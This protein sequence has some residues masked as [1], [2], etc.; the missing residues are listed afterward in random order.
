[1]N[2]PQFVEATRVLAQNSV[3]V[4]STGIEREID[5][6]GRTPTGARLRRE[7]E[8]WLLIDLIRTIWLTTKS[9]PADADKLLHRGIEAPAAL[10]LRLSWP[11]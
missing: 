5:L 11:R 7:R 3:A 2:D 6:H 4:G 1:M 10:L 8:E 9:D